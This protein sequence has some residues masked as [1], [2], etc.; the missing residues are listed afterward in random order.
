MTVILDLDYTLLDT[1]R[2]KEALVQTLMTCGPTRQQI[3]AAYSDV[4]KR[5]GVVYDY[6]PDLQLEL[7]GDAVTCSRA[8]AR[9]RLGE[10]AERTGDFLYPGAAVFLQRLKD[11]GAKLVLLTLGNEQWQS[12]KV[13]R[14]SLGRYF[15]RVVA[16]AGEKKDVI[17]ALSDPAGK[18]FV[19]NDNPEETLAM[20]KNAPDF[21]YL[22]KAGPKPVP[23]GYPFT[24]YQNFSEI[25]AA[26]RA[27]ISG[28][29][30]KR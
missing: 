11:M 18:T 5:P 22:T 1:V 27:A 2:F 14:S 3:D 9:R 12:E 26:I 10:V 20:A 13:R 28:E 19:V 16:S 23:A 25:E 24:V 15:D 8:E 7:L 6:D 29:E 21:I 4:V 17:A 30:M